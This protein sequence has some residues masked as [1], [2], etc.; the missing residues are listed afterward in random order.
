MIYILD[1]T[2]KTVGVA[3]NGSPLAM[4]YMDDLHIENLIGVSSYEFSVPSQ[5][6]ES[7]KLEVN[8]HVIIKDLDGNF[9]LFTIKSIIDGYKEGMQIK[10]VY[11]ENTA[12]SELLTDV[13]R[14][15][16]MNSVTLK[17]VMESIMNN[18]ALWVLGEVEDDAL[19]DFEV[20]EHSTVLETLRAVASQYEVDLFFNVELNGTKIVRKTVNAISA[21]GKET[22]VRFDYGYDLSEVAKTED[23]SQVITALVGVGKGDTAAKRLSLVSVPAFTEGDYYKLDSADWIASKSAL[24]QWSI[25]GEHLFG[26]FIDEEATNTAQ[27][28]SNTMKE[29]AKRI[30][31]SLNYSCTLTTLERLTGYSSKR[32]RVGDRVVIKDRTYNPPI[33]VSGRVNELQRS[34]TDSTKDTV[35]LGDYKPVT[36]YT[37]RNIKDLQDIISRNEEKWNATATTAKIVANGGT[38]FRN[39]VGETTLTANVF[40]NQEEKDIYGVE[41][42][43]RWSKY[44]ENGNLVVAFNHLGKTLTVT[45]DDIVDKATYVVDIEK[46]STVLTRDIITLVELYDGEDG[47]DGAQGVPGPPGSDGQTLYTWIKYANSNLGEGISDLPNGKAFIGFAYNKTSALET[48][49]PYDYAWSLIQGEAGTTGADGQTL[50]TWIKYADTNTGTGMS[51]S[52]VGKKFMGIKYNNVSST[53]STNAADYTWSPIYD[54]TTQATV[55]GV[56]TLTDGWKFTGKTSIDGGKIETDS[57][58]AAQIKAGAITADELSATAINGKSISG[59]TVTGSSFSTTSGTGYYGV[60]ESGHLTLDNGWP[61]V[62]NLNAFGMQVMNQYGET[63]VDIVDV[64]NFGKRGNYA[65]I[66]S[67]EGLKIILAKETTVEGNL[68]VD[69][70][71][72]YP[73]TIE[74][75]GQVTYIKNG[76]GNVSYN[77]TSGY[78][79]FYTDRS[80]FYINAPVTFEGGM[81]VNSGQTAAFNGGITIGGNAA[82]KY[83]NSTSSVPRAYTIGSV[84]VSVDHATN[85][86]V[87]WTYPLPSFCDLVIAQPRDSQSTAYKTAIMEVSRT[88]CRVYINHIHISS[89]SGTSY[90]V[91][92]DLIA[93]GS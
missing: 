65:L 86:Y 48:N 16:T 20:E 74:N 77:I 50:Y 18:S 46:D 19:N 39:G 69:G 60:L 84:S 30:T 68:I 14:P 6:E 61:D 29:L 17:T 78:V 42:I 57:I 87:T 38:I 41:Y 63:E 31:P 67:P 47:I 28:K 44:D 75:N 1:K 43:Y 21:R 9:L 37:A 81:S 64:A 13:V 82:L 32:V 5:H 51:D 26:I 54:E 91:K 10:T 52:P 35:D 71:G 8:G 25:N 34:Y 56:K 90:T 79:D 36:L 11:C 92:F 70:V 7:L 72:S 59:V 4:P 73:T 76:I 22:L 27:L 12:I 53:E 15:M 45:K 40:F 49:D 24:Q 62:I 33:V 88:G 2:Q 66:D 93:F 55:E 83:L 89:P 80:R 85:T 3:V 23:S 58:T